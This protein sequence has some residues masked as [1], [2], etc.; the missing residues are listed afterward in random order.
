VAIDA[1]QIFG[2]NGLTSEYPMEK[3]LRDSRAMLIADARQGCSG[4]WRGK[5][6]G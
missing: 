4:N 3:L 5:W 2:G 1:L 6:A